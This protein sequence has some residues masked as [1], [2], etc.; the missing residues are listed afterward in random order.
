MTFRITLALLLTCLGWSA[1]LK[2]PDGLNYTAALHPKGYEVQIPLPAVGKADIDVQPFNPDLR[3]VVS[4]VRT[5]TKT[6]EPFAVIVRFDDSASPRLKPGTYRLL[7]TVTRKA[8]AGA[9]TKPESFPLTVQIPAAVITPPPALE[10]TLTAG[11]LGWNCGHPIPITYRTADAKGRLT[12]VRVEQHLPYLQDGKPVAGRLKVAVQQ[13]A[14]E[15]VRFTLSNGDKDE[16]LEQGVFNGQLLL[17]ADQLAQPVTVAVKIVRRA[18]LFYLAFF[19]V[20][21]FI[22]GH[23]LR[24]KNEDR[25][26]FLALEID[27]HRLLEQI[28]ALRGE[29]ADPALTAELQAVESEIKEKL[30]ARSI[31]AEELTKFRERV[32]TA[33]KA[34]VAAAKQLTDDAAAA[35]ARLGNRQLP[36]ELQDVVDLARKSIAEAVILD[37]NN[38]TAGR[39]R[40]SAAIAAFHSGVLRAG[41][42]WAHEFSLNLELWEALKPLAV[43]TDLPELNTAVSAFIDKFKA[44][45]ALLTNSSLTA[46]QAVQT[47]ESIHQLHPQ[48][49]PIHRQFPRLWRLSVHE[50]HAEFQLKQLDPGAPWN[51]QTATIARL[52]GLDGSQQ[53]AIQELHSSLDTLRAY[54][55]QHAEAVKDPAKK[56][57]ALAAFDKG[58]WIEV[59]RSLDP[60]AAPVPA[61]GRIPDAPESGNIPLVD[62]APASPEPSWVPPPPPGVTILRLQS[63]LEQRENWRRIF[64]A[65]ILSAA[66]FLA[67]QT[68]YTGSNL[69]F[70]VAFSWA[71]STDLLAANAVAL[72]SKGFP[73]AA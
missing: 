60:G 46:E 21:G 44:V 67:L 18:S 33:A 54:L 51:T 36:S 28:T 11:C 61:P 1:E 48:W 70:L 22:A 72:V 34:L 38:V 62:Q 55:R 30:T 49:P 27:S 40:L 10:L 50:L 58:K 23:F 19:I 43:A 73:K 15:E 25:I 37:R 52:I 3:S 65:A 39:V 59:I 71:Y 31:K 66:G 26:A 63:E 13:G 57:V 64:A 35:M 69:D 32:D 29:N 56:T 5:E 9:D 20:A 6:G 53:Q 17:S 12:G 41:R 24:K 2:L 16:A 45:S 42:T 4:L 14:P 68:T 8:A 47:L 7:L